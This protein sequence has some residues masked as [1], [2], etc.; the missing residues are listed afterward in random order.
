MH[1]WSLAVEE[2]FYIVW[3]LV[4]LGVMRF[5]RS[6]R[7]LLALCVAAAIGTAVWTHVVYDGGLNQNRAFLGTDTRSQCLFIGCA[8]AVALVML[9]H[10]GHEEGRLAKGELWRP[11]TAA[12]RHLC[13]TLG[14]I[15]AV[16][17]VLMWVLTTSFSSFPYHGGFFVI[18][19]AVAAVIL[20]AVAVPQSIV[21]RLLSV[22]PVRYVGRIS[23]GLYL[24]HWPVFIWLNHERTGLTGYWLF[25]LRVL[26]TFAISVAS[27]HLVERPIRMG[28]FFRQW[29]AW[30]AVPAGVGVV[31]AAVVAATTGTT[32]VASTAIPAGFGTTG[33]TTSSVPAAS[34][35]PVRVL[36][37]GDSVALTLGLGLSDSAAQAKYGYVLSDKGILGCGVVFGPEVEIMGARDVTPAACDGS[38]LTAGEPANQQPW[39]YQW[40]A[41]INV[42]HP[43]VVVVLA[44]RWEVVDREYQGQWTNI[45]SPA[46]AAYVKQQLEATSKLVTSAGSH[47]VFLTA[48]CTSEGEQ[49]DGAPWPEDDPARVAEFNKLLRQVAGAHPQTDSVVDLNAAACPRG[50]FAS[51]VDGVVMRRTDGVHFTLAGGVA[52]IPALMPAIVASGRAQMAGA[53]LAGTTTSTSTTG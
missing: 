27:F 48:P 9:A 20:S 40:L 8:L 17:A 34:G 45:L 49:P 29:R 18:G 52:L 21:P 19:V 11:T 4:V 5:T 44:G 12:G 26:V 37:F 51:T 33:T 2:Q 41:A 15:G 50:K 42:V 31:L 23:Y 24:W 7:A 3:P 43:N 53:G 6:L 39:P 46:Y 1:T 36:L 38:Q 30:V 10:R 25:A 47:L 14:I 28:T 35:P 13:A 32:A 16:V 22:T